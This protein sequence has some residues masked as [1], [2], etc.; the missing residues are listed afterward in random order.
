MSAAAQRL[1]KGNPSNRYHFGDGQDI[2]STW[3]S[4]RRA[5][6]E[7]LSNDFQGAVSLILKRRAAPRFAACG[8]RDLH[9]LSGARF[10]SKY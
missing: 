4:R 10:N 3:R 7:S 2:K 6:A 9:L 5:V 8:H 1:K